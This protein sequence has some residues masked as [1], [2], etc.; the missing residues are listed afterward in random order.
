MPDDPTREKPPADDPAEPTPKSPEEMMSALLNPAPSAE[1]PRPPE[2]YDA[3]LGEDEAKRYARPEDLPVER[4]AKP[5]AD[6]VEPAISEAARPFIDMRNQAATLADLLNKEEI[7]FEDYQ[8]LLYEAMAQD[9]GGFWWMIDAENDDWYRHDPERK[10]WVV[11]YP[12]ALREYEDQKSDAPDADETLTEYELPASYS[13]PVAGDPIYD[14]RGVKIGTVPPTKDALYTVPGAAA[15]ADEIPGQQPTLAADARETG[16][17]RAAQVD[18]IPRAIDSNYE[19]GTSP[20][21]SELLAARRGRRT[22]L[23]MTA[24]AGLLMLAL[25]ASIITAGVIMMWYRDTIEPFSAGIAALGNYSPAYQSA[26][27][28]DMEGGLL[29]SLN[30]QE[31]GARITVPL[32]E[33]SPYM[34]HAIVSQE[35]ERFFDDPGFDPVAIVRAFLQN[36][37]GGGIESGASTI[38]QQIARNLVLGDREVTVQRKLNEI[39]VALEIANRYNKDFIL[40]LYLNEIFFANQTY[41]VEAASNFYFGHGA[42]KLNFAQ[43]ALLASIVP[44]PVQQDPVSN[45]AAAVVGMRAT[46]RKMIAVGCLQFQHGDWPGRGPF[47]IIAGAETD[48]NGARAVLVNT[49]DSGEII[50][51]AAILQIAEIETTH[52]QPREF[53]VRY[54][55]FVDYVR[56]AI[57]AELGDEALFQRGLSI[58]TTL[59]PA[60]QDVA[61]AALSEQVRRLKGAASGVNTGAVMITDPSSG[62]IRAL[63]GSHDFYDVHAG[64]V[65]NALTFQQPGSAIK[66]FVYLA[67]LQNSSENA[68]TPASIIWDVPLVE[69]LGAGG[70]YEPQNIDRRFHGPVSL[71]TALQNSYNIPTVKVFRDHVGVGHFA[72]TADALGLQFPEDS[73]FSLASALGANEVTLFDMMGAYAVLANGGRRVPLYAI[74]RIT[75]TVDGEQVEIPLERSAGEEAISPA[76]AYLMQNIL[77]DDG[78]RAPSF[79]PGSNLTLAQQ[80]IPTH[81][82]VAAKTGTTNG[83]RD[84]WTMGFSRNAVVGVWLGTSDNSPTYNTSG[85]RSA[86]P[87]WNSVM[88]AASNWYPPAP[89]E[90]PGGVVAR[91]ICRST[92]TLNFP[93]C[94]EP[95]TDLFLQ[96]QYPPAPEAAFLQRVAVDSWTLLRANE[97]CTGHVIEQNFAAVP[98]AAALDW[99]NNSEEGRDYAEKLGLRIPVAPPPQAACAQGQQ[100]PLINLSSPNNGAVIR[101]AVELR[102]QVQAPALD[103]FELLYAH[104]DNPNAF[105][106]ISASLVQMPQY[107][108]P[109]GLWDTMAAQVPNGDIILRLAATSLS[110]GFINFDLNVSVDNSALEE[111]EPA[112]GP[113]VENIII[114][115]PVATN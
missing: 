75:E 11:D 54:P 10:Q 45:R 59:N 62:A 26:R 80:G 111:G 86:A 81:N 34:I 97:F 105:Y 71:R 8:R 4:E 115:T 32:D 102:G 114:P 95:T 16:A 30:S 37:R 51:G 36:L 104:A 103:R 90:N 31:T 42:D 22:R 18:A 52:F 87:L 33:I 77:S 84:L 58:H 25:A 67:A 47:C 12:A 57:E 108:S 29:A 68:L 69:D 106:P 2:D 41:G 109:L 60:L 19:L 23:L 92:G 70:I 55:H 100:L 66:P 83:G 43:A 65:N 3:H 27:I 89:F 44:S 76:L 13:A 61:Q 107:G 94:P 112:F 79:P 64:Q 5:A 40:E 6:L 17:T 9:E 53:Q 93:A 91:E 101:G 85:Y 38:T 50:G 21:V 74:E 88:A 46:M 110:G 1:A 56:A 99:L 24:L 20:V 48:L 63:V 49:G 14:D 39:L 7:S 113:T 15:L 98:D 96:G 78:A 28:F 82:T 72:N 73:F 35:N